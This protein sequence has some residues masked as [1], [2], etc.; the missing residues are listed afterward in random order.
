MR[1]GNR[2]DLARSRAKQ[3]LAWGMGDTLAHHAIGQ[4]ALLFTGRVFEYLHRSGQNVP[5][6]TLSRSSSKRCP[7]AAMIAES[8]DGSSPSGLTAGAVAVKAGVIAGAV[9]MW[10]TMR[11][12]SFATVVVSISS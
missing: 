8:A 12:A 4:F 5:P 2:R 11:C 6:L 7:I 9:P 10:S 3:G 1:F